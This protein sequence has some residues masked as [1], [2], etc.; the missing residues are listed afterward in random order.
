MD[1]PNVS[2]K[3]LDLV[4]NDRKDNDPS[5]SEPLSLVSC[6]TQVVHGAYN[7]GQRSTD[8]ELDKAR[9]NCFSIFK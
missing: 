8:L 9:K 2:W 7:V 4:G 1:S 6:V 3:L 5:A